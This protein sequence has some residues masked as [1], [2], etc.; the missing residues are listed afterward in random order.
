MKGAL[1]LCLTVAAMLA[2]GSGPAFAHKIIA[3]VFASGSSV[4][5]EVGM[6][7]GTMAADQTVEVFGPD[8]Q[9]LGEATTDADGFFL[10]TPTQP[11][12]HEFR[13]D[14]GMGHVAS[15]RM[16]AEE[17][18]AILGRQPNAASTAPAAGATIAYAPAPASGATGLSLEEREAIAEIVR[19]E[20]RSLRQEIAAYKEKNDLQT[21]LGGIGYI[22][23]LFGIGFYVAARQRLRDSA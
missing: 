7:D 14:L 17:I 20:T 18:G 16:G 23:G 13:V 1:G 21:I 12:A 6:S 10:F 3:S 8:G 22:L 15:A 5:G 19:T 11:V 2:F 4:E 9:K